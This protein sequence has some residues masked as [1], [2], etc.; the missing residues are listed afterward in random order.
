M[1]PHLQRRQRARSGAHRWTR[2][3]SYRLEIVAE[4]GA[5]GRSLDSQ[6]VPLRG[7]AMTRAQRRS[8]TGVTPPTTWWRGPSI[9][10]PDLEEQALAPPDV[11]FEL[12]GEVVLPA[13]RFTSPAPTRQNFALVQDE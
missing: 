2:D 3:G 11:R 10:T 9:V 12:R 8:L 6:L 5:Q 4:T 13:L 1:A 7:R